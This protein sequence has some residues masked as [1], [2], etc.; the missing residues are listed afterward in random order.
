M[1]LISK[2]ILEKVRHIEIRTS[3]LVDDM[4]GGAYLSAFKGRGMEFEEVR[5]YEPGDDVR[6]ID[7]NVTARMSRP[8]VKNFREERELTVMLVVDV[9]ASGRFGSHQRTKRELI[10]EIGAVLAFSAIKNNDKVGLILFSDRV[11][12]YLPPKKGVRHVLRIIRE[13]LVDEPEGK[14]TDVA[15]A[16]KFLQQVQRKKGVCFLISDFIAPNFRQALNIAAR[17]HDLI[18]L[19]VTDPHEINFPSLGLV[20]IRDLESGEL[21]LVDSSDPLFRELSRQRVLSR[22]E[23]QKAAIEKAGG[24]FIDVRTDIPYTE[25]IR[26]YFAL[27]RSHRR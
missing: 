6:S 22:I 13:L 5:E 4:L 24:G 19:C 26:R 11:E 15:G 8:F 10:A 20:P 23:E 1:A 2:E 7:W 16:L 21:L 18:G 27:R 14:G 3:H 25:A 17:C 9:S 12:K